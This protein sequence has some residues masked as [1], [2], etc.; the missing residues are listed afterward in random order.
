MEA[1]LT[2]T[3]KYQAICISET[4]LS[5][6][7]LSLIN[8]NG[9]KIAASYCRE[10]RGGGGV[11]ILIE[12]Q[13]NCIERC[14]ITNLS[15]EYILEVCATE[16]PNENILLV[17]MYWNRREEV[18]FYSQLNHILTHITKKYS[19][20]NIILG[21]DFNIDILKN[22]LYTNTFLDLMSQ[23]GYKQHVK[24]PTHIT[25][26]ISTCLD[27]IFTNFESGSL[28]TTVEDLGFSDHCGT[29]ITFSIPQRPK[30]TIWYTEKRFYS[31]NN[32]DEF[33]SKLKM[34]NWTDIIIKTENINVNYTAFSNLVTHILNQTIPKIKIKLKTSYQKYWLTKGIKISCTNKRLLKTLCLKSDSPIIK[35][36]YKKYEKILNADV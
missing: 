12:E 22:N 30:Q 16:I 36:Y 33:K 34:V 5:Q 2:T 19:K 24:Q 31:N 17:A 27:L 20:Y 29:I 35:K 10:N 18:T 14:D 4:W 32:I 21:G 11:C 7:K 6:N 15:L 28:C 1:F 23:Y 8:F 25:L 3:N 13:K 9:Y 26:T